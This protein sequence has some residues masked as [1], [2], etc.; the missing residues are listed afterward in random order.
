MS[1][2]GYSPS[3]M[4]FVFSINSLHAYVLR[5]LLCVHRDIIF[6][7]R[8]TSRRISHLGWLDLLLLNVAKKHFS[9][10]KKI[11]RFCY[12][13]AKNGSVTKSTELAGDLAGEL[14]AKN[15]AII[16]KKC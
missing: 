4:K 10:A 9:A 3:F 13:V 14:V 1:F 8:V 7:P 2:V 5:K 11:T 6:Q 16:A 15:Y 12:N